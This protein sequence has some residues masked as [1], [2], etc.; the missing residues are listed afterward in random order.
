LR[1][2]GI[3]PSQGITKLDTH[4]GNVRPGKPAGKPAGGTCYF[5]GILKMRSSETA[6]NWT[7]LM[8]QRNT[9]RPSA[10]WV[11]VWG[12]RTPSICL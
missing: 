6:L 1:I 12:M 8:V 10:V 4:Y 2:G 11:T 3:L 9:I 5:F 7:L